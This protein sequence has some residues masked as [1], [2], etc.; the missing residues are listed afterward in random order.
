MKI[1]L[2]KTRAIY[3]KNLKDLG[4]AYKL[5]EIEKIISE[6]KDL[7]KTYEDLADKNKIKIKDLRQ[8]LSQMAENGKTLKKEKEVRKYPTKKFWISLKILKT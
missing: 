4:T 1:S 8:S 7:L 3:E 2:E 6:N 5:N